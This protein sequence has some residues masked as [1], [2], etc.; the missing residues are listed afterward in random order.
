MVEAAVI[1]EVVEAGG[2]VLVPGDDVVLLAAHCGLVAAG[3]GLAVP[4]TDIMAPSASLSFANPYG[5]CSIDNHPL[6][7]A[8]PPSR[9]IKPF[10]ILAAVPSV[11]PWAVLAI[12]VR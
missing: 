5:A 6:S 4:V 11:R 3:G 2:A 12:L 8:H 9:A 10:A 1:T 7:C